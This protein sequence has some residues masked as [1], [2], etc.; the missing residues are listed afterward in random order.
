V[1]PSALAL[2]ALAAAAIGCTGGERVTPEALEQA[3]Q[4]WTRANIRDYDLDWT[5]SGPN[6]AHYFV[7]VRGGEVRTVESVQ[8]DGS[9]RELH[10]GEPR[11]FSVDGL[12]LTIADEIVLQ[13][14]DRPFGQPTGTAVVMRFKPD[15]KLGYPHWYRRDL[16]GTSMNI[17]I[18]VN[19]LTPVGGNSQ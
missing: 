12:F 13:K 10:P 18:E 6:N 8:H 14:T 16:L 7:T 1:K 17:S 19:Q 4:L 9:R 3:K 2:T 15:A 11:F 5:V